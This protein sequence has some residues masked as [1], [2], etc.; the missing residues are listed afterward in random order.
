MS[1]GGAQKL[2]FL[3][4]PSQGWQQALAV[5][6]KVGIDECPDKYEDCIANVWRRVIKSGN[7]NKC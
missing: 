3:T 5:G 1:S 2:V 4:I 6:G 7:P